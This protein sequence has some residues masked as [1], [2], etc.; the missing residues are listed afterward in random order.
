[1]ER[2]TTATFIGHSECYGLDEGR[3]LATIEQ[4]IHAGITT[5]LCGGMGAFDWLCARQ[6]YQAKQQYS[7]MECLLVIPYLS[8]RIRE[9][10]YFDDILYP[11][12]FEKYHFKAAIPERKR[13]MVNHSSYALCYVDHDWGGAAKTYRL[14]VRQGLR[15]INLGELDNGKSHI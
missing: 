8:F 13:F 12:G 11:E 3:V 1:M 9:R 4:L 7:E 2:S 10:K 5:F 6:V 14:A 15:I